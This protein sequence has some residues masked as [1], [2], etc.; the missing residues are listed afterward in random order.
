MVEQRTTVSRTRQI[1]D[2]F[3]GAVGNRIINTTP[4]YINSVNI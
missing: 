1:H 2:R 4:S 3:L